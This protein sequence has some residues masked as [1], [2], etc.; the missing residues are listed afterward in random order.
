MDKLHELL[1]YCE[2]IIDVDHI[3]ESTELLKKTYSFEKTGK[4]ALK[5]AY[6]DPRFKPYSIE[7][8]HQDMGKM[9]YNE[10]ISF[11]PSLEIKDDT[12]PMLRA[13]Y[14]VGCLPCYFGA[15]DRIMNGDMPWVQ[16][17][18]PEALRQAIDRGCPSPL[19][20]H[21]EQILKTYQF[22]RDTLSQYPKCNEAIKLF[23]PDFQ[24]PLDVAHLLYGSE[25]YADM[26]DDPDLIH[27]LLHLITESYIL[28]M[29]QIK[30]LLN[31]ETGDGYCY[32]WNYLFPGN[33]VL[34]NDSAVNLSAAMYAEFAQPYDERIAQAFGGASM[35]FCG[36]GDQWVHDM[37]H[38][39]HHLALNFGRVKGLIYGQEF[40]DFLAPATTDRQFPLGMYPITP[41]E[42]HRLDLDKYS[43]GITYTVSCSSKEEAL[44]L[45]AKYH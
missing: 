21:G 10:I 3:Q 24:G 22:Y 44:A 33:I 29:N 43:T 19:E 41:D 9:M 23:H 20:G 14:G 31:D 15:T 6:P 5:L 30:P 2:E 36:R 27:E 32:H 4:L 28:L 11:L 25:I 26:Y 40:L 18:T 45:L 17:M 13:N 1:S 34:R 7:E 37:A 35:H 39:K 8:I 16:H 42:L 12:L 38:A